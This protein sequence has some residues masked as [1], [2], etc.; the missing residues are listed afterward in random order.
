MALKTTN[1]TF[2]DVVGIG[3]AI[4]DVMAKVGDGFLSE[5]NLPKGLSLCVYRQGS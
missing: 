3:N 2:Y 5:R 4:V 1:T